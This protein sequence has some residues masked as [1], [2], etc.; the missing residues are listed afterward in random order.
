M[1]TRGHSVIA[2]APDIN[3]EIKASL[4]TLGAK[5]EPL[6]LQR[7][8]QSISSDLAYLKGLKALIRRTGPDLVLTYTIKPNIWGSFAAKAEGVRSAAML[9]GL[10]FAFYEDQAGLNTQLMRRMARA[11]YRRATSASWRVIF[12]NPD[13]RDDFISAGCLKDPGKVRM[14]NG[15]GVDLAQF[16]PAPLPDKP[17]FLMI[18]RLLKSKGIAE[19]AEAARLLKET[20]PNAECRLVGPEDPGVDG[21]SPE[22]LAI[23][24]AQGLVYL[25]PKDDVRPEIT[26]A[27]VYVLPSYREGT[28]RSNLEAMAMGRPVVTTDAPG[29]RTTVNDGMNGFLVPVGKSTPLAARM[30]ELAE[31]AALRERMGAKSLELA[32]Q[33]FD[34]HK[35]NAALLA[36]LEL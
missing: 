8:G 30:A 26:A 28:P 31:D 27:S 17:V 6:D 34:V 22:N 16:S 20:H 18:S 13:D 32:Q 19:Y 23:W 12:Q 10:G 14:V 11:L 5:V 2:C 25:G 4:A 15:S 9:T 1:V 7:T 36:H 24:Q 3:S 33:K 29:C 21:I 35:V